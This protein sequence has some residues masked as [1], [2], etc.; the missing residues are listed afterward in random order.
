VSTS[1]AK[2]PTSGIHPPTM[3][4]PIERSSMTSERMHDHARRAEIIP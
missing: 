3:S 4:E 1:T 2:N